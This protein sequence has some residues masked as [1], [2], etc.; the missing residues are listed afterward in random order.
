M[1][2]R[3]K[4]RH[5]EK[6]KLKAHQA[7]REA[8][9]HYVGVDLVYKRKVRVILAGMDRYD[10]LCLLEDNEKNVEKRKDMAN[11]PNNVLRVYLQ[12]YY[13]VTLEEVRKAMGT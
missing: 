7:E 8:V 6:A 1:A 5:V 12:D 13:K 3:I 2:R 11:I 4:L 9:H 10:L